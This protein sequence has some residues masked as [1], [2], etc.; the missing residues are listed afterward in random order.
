MSWSKPAARGRGRNTGFLLLS[1]LFFLLVSLH[2]EAAFS[3]SL[4]VKIRQVNPDSAI[5][6][7]NCAERAKCVLPID[8]QTGTT[9]QTLTVHVHFVPV[10]FEFET[11]KGFLYAGDKS[12]A[13]KQNAVYQTIWTK[14][15]AQSKSTISPVTLFLPL[16]PHAEVAPMLSAVQQPV[17]DLEITTVQAP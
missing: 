12:P 4:T 9:K 1:G 14:G 16:V 5:Q 7:V 15:K 2:S 13:D 17:A 3:A 10:L 6:E 8:I 11:P